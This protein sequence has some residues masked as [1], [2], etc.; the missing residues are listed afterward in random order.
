MTTATVEQATRACEWC[1]EQIPQRA[2]R[3][4]RCQ[5]WRKDIE[6][7]RVLC[8]IWSSLVIFPGFVFGLG[9]AAGWWHVRAGLLGPDFF[10]ISRFF[11]S[12]S[13]MFVFLTVALT[14][15]VSTYYYVKVSRLMR[16]WFWM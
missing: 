11:G 5:K 3:C 2:V 6:Q 10:A 13:G 16:S 14:L 15:T 4:P 12:P 1:A 9:F 8:Y 7:G